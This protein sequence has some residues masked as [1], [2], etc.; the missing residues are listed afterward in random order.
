MKLTCSQTRYLIAVYKLSDDEEGVRPIAIAE[1]LGVTSPSVSRMLNNLT[2]MGLLTKKLYGNVFMTER[3]RAL[4]EERCRKLEQLGCQL[5]TFF[6][7]PSNLAE[8]CALLLIS[9]LPQSI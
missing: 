7:I 2:K 3:G 4:A 5:E 9:E 8:E 1:A 6:E